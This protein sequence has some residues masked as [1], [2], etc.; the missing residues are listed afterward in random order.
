MSHELYNFANGDYSMAFTGDTPWHELG[1]KVDQ[2]APLEIWAQQSHLDWQIGEAPG[3]FYPDSEGRVRP[4]EIPGKKILYRKDSNQFL[5]VVSNRYN[6]VQPIEV[7]EFFRD[8]VESGGFKMSTAGSML[9]GK[10]IWALAEIG[11]TAAIMG[12]DKIGGYLLLATSCDG[13]LANTGQFTSVRVVC[14]NTL[15]MSI[16]AGESG[17]SRRYI[18]IPHSRVFDPNEMKAE[19][20]LAHK[21]FETFVE[22]A[23]VLAQRKTTLDEAV[24]FFV[25]LYQTDEEKEQGIVNES[26]VNT[27]HV[28]NLIRLF[29]DEPLKTSQGTAWGIV[30]AVTKYYDHER[31]SHSID[32]RLNNA[33]FGEGAGIK[34]KAFDQALLL[35]A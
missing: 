3:L 27:F 9:G 1:Q 6:V 26:T 25:G 35:A 4:I 30:N 29:N 13:S 5:S 15:E 16:N 23:A 2:N 8:L 18:K 22:N 21:T 14:N 28:K 19:L 20:G 10:R 34:K 12:I 7:I 24:K 17:Q 33:W 31:R 11:E 32:T